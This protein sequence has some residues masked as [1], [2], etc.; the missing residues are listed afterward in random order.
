MNSQ[1]LD[2]SPIIQYIILRKDLIDNKKWT[3]GALMAQACH[4]STSAI[5][6]W[7]EDIDV[8]KYMSDLDNMHKI[9]LQVSNEDELRSISK[10]LSD[11][12]ICHKLWI[13][14]PEN[15]PTALAIKP[16]HKSIFGCLLQKL[17]LF[18]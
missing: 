16:Y 5:W 4:A 14:Q 3:Q 8:Q 9:L 12:K 11:N 18:R 2:E 15:I 6:L 1:Q 7:K 13:E 10:L 17:K